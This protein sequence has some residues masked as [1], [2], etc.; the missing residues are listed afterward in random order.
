MAP[1]PEDPV[2]HLNFAP[3]HNA[4]DRLK[5]IAERYDAS[6]KAQ[7]TLD[8][9]TLAAINQLLISTE[10]AMTH[11]EG[12]PRRPWFQHLVYAPGFYTG[13]GV[14]TLPGVREAIE[15]RAWEEAETQIQHAGDMMN[16]V[17]DTLDKATKTIS[18]K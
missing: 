7:D 3:L 15:Q 9:S 11:E 2:P 6:L 4:F 18:A 12:L 1:E 14:K 10:R 17:A 13:Y 8:E 16:R 5:A